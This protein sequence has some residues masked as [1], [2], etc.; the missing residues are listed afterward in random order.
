MSNQKLSHKTNFL[1]YIAKERSKDEFSKI[2]T[3]NLREIEEKG[4]SIQDFKEERRVK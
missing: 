2:P 4:T 3:K 1:Q